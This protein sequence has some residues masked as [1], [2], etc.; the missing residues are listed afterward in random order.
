MKRNVLLLLLLLLLT[1]NLSVGQTAAISA[2]ADETRY[3]LELLENQDHG[4]WSLLEPSDGHKLLLFSVHFQHSN[5]L[6][7][8]LCR[9]YLVGARPLV[10]GLQVSDL[11]FPFHSFW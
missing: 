2:P 10:L 9:H 8:G 11:I 4:I 1:P 5:P 3:G 6:F 7:R